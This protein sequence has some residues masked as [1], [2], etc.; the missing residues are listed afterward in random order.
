MASVRV[1]TPPP[2]SSMRIPPT[3]K[4]A[5]DYEPYSPPRKSSRISSQRAQRQ[6]QTPPPQSRASISSTKKVASTTMPNS[7]PLTVTKKRM[8]IARDGRRISGSLNEDT[9][10]SAASALGLP[11]KQGEVVASESAT[12]STTTRG[13]LPT[14]DKTPRKRPS[15]PTPGISSIA[16]N[17]FPVRPESIEEVMPSPKKKK[18]KKYSGFTLDSFGAEDADEPITIFTDSQ[19]RIPEVDVSD[20]N[21]FYS[22]GAAVP[23]PIKRASKRR[24]ITV[25][26]EGELTVEDVQKREDGLV[27]VL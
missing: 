22:A 5:G 15:K 1:S 6:A 8:Q 9:M 24:K 17:L 2:P 27:Y 4:H 21:P 7:P 16:R 13:M 14:P 26:G 18:N 19:E 12:R 11:S 10:T 20:D 23:E 25:P 3:P